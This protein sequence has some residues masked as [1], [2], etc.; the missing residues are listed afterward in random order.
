VPNL[1]R[2][3]LVDP[4]PLWL[5][6]VSS[7]L[8]AEIEVVAT[9]PST[10]QV[11]ELVEELEPEVVVTETDD[12][13]TTDY[14]RRIRRASPSTRVIILTSDDSVERIDEAL[15]GGAV[16]YV[17]KTALPDDLSVAVRQAFTHS[18]F[19]PAANGNGHVAR[20]KDEGEAE[21]VR[22]NLTRRELEILLLVAEGESNAS[23]AQRL[24]VTE[25]TVKFHLSNVYKKLDVANR[26]EAAHWAAR[27]GLLDPSRTAAA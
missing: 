9:T 14:V 20:E 1:R 3:I 19:L 23:V 13:S 8:R 16:A 10:E 27:T 21:K 6:A 26:T 5:D 15:A 18:V 4:H 22:H 25:Q 7:A 24:W 2:A 11:I 12:V 17:I